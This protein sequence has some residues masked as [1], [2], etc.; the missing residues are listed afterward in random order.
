MHQAV[1]RCVLTWM[2]SILYPGSHL[3]VSL[4]L[5]LITIHLMW[6]IIGMRGE[7]HF[8]CQH[9]SS[10]GTCNLGIGII[11]HPVITF[12]SLGTS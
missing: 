7:L 12:I 10:M 8:P 3:C 11:N 5:S 1:A 6:L 9:K 4:V 2:V